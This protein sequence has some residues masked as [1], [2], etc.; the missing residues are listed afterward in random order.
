MSV[1]SG[2][3]QNQFASC[4][5]V[6]LLREWLPCAHWLGEGGRWYFL[7]LSGWCFTPESGKVSLNEYSVLWTLDNFQQCTLLKSEELCTGAQ[8]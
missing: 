2:G 7:L 3:E 5:K 6:S 8:L 4:I 1:M